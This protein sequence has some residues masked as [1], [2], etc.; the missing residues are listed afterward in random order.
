LAQFKSDWEAEHALR[1][2]KEIEAPVPAYPLAENLIEF[3]PSATASFRFFID[4]ASLSVGADGV[5]RYTLVARS[6]S[7]VDNV[8]FEGIRCQGGLVRGYATGKA[9]RTWTLRTGSQWR[10]IEP[11]T[12]QRWHQALRREYF[13]PQNA[14]IRDAAEGIHALRL[15]GHP[16]KAH[17]SHD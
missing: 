11:K 4:S 8:S 12:M 3:Q 5:V 6:P 14:I 9:D 15:G 17:T 13:C 7:G 16:N 10:E 2:W 1:N